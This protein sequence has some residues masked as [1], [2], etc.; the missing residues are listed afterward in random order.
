MSH[1]LGKNPGRFHWAFWSFFGAA[2]F[3]YSV[4][5]ANVI[6][7]YRSSDIHA[8]YET[9]EG[10]VVSTAVET[11]RLKASHPHAQVFHLVNGD[12]AGMGDWTY[13]DQG[14][15]IYKI[16]SDL[17]EEASLLVNLGNHE[18]FDFRG[19]L[20]MDLFL[21]QNRDFIRAIRKT[22]LNKDFKLT[23][24]NIVPTK[25]GRAFFQ[26]RTDHVS[27]AGKR[28]RFVGLVLDDFYGYSTFDQTAKRKPFSALVPILEQAKH[29]LLLARD[30]GVDAVVFMVH[31]EHRTVEQWLKALL[32]W[33]D[34]VAGMGRVHLP[35]AFSAH[36]HQFA[37]SKI[38][39]TLLLDGGSNFDYVRVDLDEN[40]K[41]LEFQNMPRS[42]QAETLKRQE[43]LDTLLSSAQKRAIT[44]AKTEIAL[45]NSSLGQS[46]VGVT[47]GFSDTRT[48][49]KRG[50]RTLGTK[51][52]DMLRSWALREDLEQGLEL[53]RSGREFFGIWNSGTYRMNGPVSAGQMSKLTLFKFYPSTTNGQILELSGGQLQAFYDALM[54]FGA[55][56]NEYIPQMSQNLFADASGKLHYRSQHGATLPIDPNTTVVLALDSWLG[57]NGFEIPAIDTI[58]ASARRIPSSERTILDV[59][60]EF[61]PAHFEKS[62][63]QPMDLC[64]LVLSPSSRVTP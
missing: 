1:Q 13:Q 5:H 64:A 38:G 39:Q 63:L 44:R 40:L 7:L 28:L 14:G 43:N 23:T 49:L 37:Q 8:S 59:L 18:A 6:R 48:D 58:F 32:A 52:A 21:K 45:L 4:A 19:Q 15:T 3:F 41:L 57:I 30:H 33:K 54:A 9:A 11:A 27:A 25:L 36:D 35:V 60:F 10:Y 61:G 62:R 55:K 34:T 17:A 24:A 22:P 31:E 26:P 2:V 53:R 20:G 47:E 50:R 46:L 16:F 42:A 51:L 12:I 56:K 29:E